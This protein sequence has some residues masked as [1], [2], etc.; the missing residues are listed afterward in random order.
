VKG[1]VRKSSFWNAKKASSE[2]NFGNH[3]FD[4]AAKSFE[5]GNIFK[6][7]NFELH[8]I[9]TAGLKVKGDV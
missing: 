4:N 6:G 1:E 9:V 8:A 2:I 5:F 3:H 7:C